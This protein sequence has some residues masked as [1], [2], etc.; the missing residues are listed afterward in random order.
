MSERSE[1]IK[2][3]QWIKLHPI[4]KNHSI[5]IPNDGKRSPILGSIYKKMGMRPGTSDIF[6]ALP[7]SGYHGF[8]IELKAGKNVAT[9]AQLQFIDDMRKENY[10]ADVIWGADNAIEAIDSYLKG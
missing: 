10:K 3:F 2:L 9:I 5:Y 1:Q 4:L 7:R 6:I 8:W